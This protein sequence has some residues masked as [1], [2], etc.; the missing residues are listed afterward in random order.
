[1]GNLNSFLASGGGNL[2]KNSNARG[3][4]GWGGGGGMFKLRSD[5]YIKRNKINI[6]MTARYGLF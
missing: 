1:M 2:N 4:P 3:L 5:R 6:F